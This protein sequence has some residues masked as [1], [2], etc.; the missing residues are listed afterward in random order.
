M[1]KKNE[2]EEKPV[3]E[4]TRLEVSF[5]VDQLIHECGENKR[6][7]KGG[8]GAWQAFQT[9]PQHIY[10]RVVENVK[11]CPWCGLALAVLEAEAEA[12]FQ[13]RIIDRLESIQ[14]E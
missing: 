1:K 9:D 3:F 10:R 7:E 11:F 14:K 6:V 12:M 13:M 5:G 8:E 4:P 2:E